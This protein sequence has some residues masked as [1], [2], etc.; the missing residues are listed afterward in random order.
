LNELNFWL[1]VTDK[2]ESF[3][4]P[5]ISPPPGCDAI[6]L[7]FGFGMKTHG[8]VYLTDLQIGGP[9]A[10]PDLPSAKPQLTRAAHPKS[11]KPG[12]S[13]RLEKVGT[14]SWLV[15]ANG[16]PFFSLGSAMYGNRMTP[17]DTYPAF[18]NLGLNTVANG[19]DLKQWSAFNDKQVADKAPVAFQ[20]CRVNTVVGDD[21]YTLVDAE[22]NNPGQSQKEAT[23]TG[24]FNHAF[25]DPFDPR[26]EAN[27]RAQI[28]E[29]AHLFKDKPYFM[30]WMAANERTHYN[31]YS[32]VWS[33]CCAVQFGLFLEHKYVKIDALNKAWK[34]QFSSFA[35]LLKQ[36]PEPLVIEGAKYEDFRLFSREILRT[37]NETLLRIIHEEDPGRLVFSNRFMIH[38][39]RGVFDNLDLYKG[40]DGIAVNIY[41]SNAV[42]GFDKGEREYLTLLHT[43]TG[44][45]LI[46]CEWSV[47]ARDSKLYDNPARLDWSYPQTVATQQQRASQTSMVLAELYNMPFVVGAH[48]FSWADFDSPQRQSNR[49]LFKANSQP[50]PELQGAMKDLILRMENDD[51]QGAK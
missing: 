10:L 45:P 13:V 22:G 6:V 8:R 30:G 48:W 38:E 19:S 23:K 4:F 36:K 37:F 49:G 24:G 28:R 7:S 44:K 16:E 1:G 26:W 5:I 31:L 12:P 18:H 29:T 3:S 20:F 42:W 34:S 21:Y 2:W 41:P 9:H 25:P 14:T 43:L 32:Y 11:F 50:W 15:D 35:D 40:F 27:V 46:I 39:V 33:P 17:E 51:K 47:P